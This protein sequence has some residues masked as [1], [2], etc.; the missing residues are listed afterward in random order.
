MDL[1]LDRLER[2]RAGSAEAFAD[3]VRLHQVMVRSYLGRFVRDRDMAENLAQETFLAAY[4]DLATYRGDAPLRRWLLGIARHQA[5]M[6]LREEA[7]R[8]ARGGESL[9][10]TLAQILTRRL[11]SAA[12]D[13]SGQEE[14]VAALK[15]CIDTL[16]PAS[17]DMVR[18]FYFRGQNAGDIARSAGKK[19][20]AVWMTLLRIRQAL[21]QCIETRLGGTGAE[22]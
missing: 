1:E 6:Y 19:E 16:A 21:R 3:L 4:R 14:R 10:G 20:G 15:R 5:L 11:E 9:E 22:A 12:G 18:G 8:R 2:A 7:R 17:R 13:L